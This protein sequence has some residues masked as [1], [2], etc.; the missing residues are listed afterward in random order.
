[1]L[2]RRHRK[3]AETPEKPNDRPRAGKALPQINEITKKEIIEQLEANNIE[4][5]PRDRKEELYKLLKEGG[6]EWKN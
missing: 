5:R 2:I 4:H 3:T 6:A 1:M